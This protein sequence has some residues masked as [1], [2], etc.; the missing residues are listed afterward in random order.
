MLYNL[1]D[2]DSLSFVVNKYP[3]KQMDQSFRKTRVVVEFAEV[4]FLYG[5]GKFFPGVE[6]EGS[7][8]SGHLVEEA[9]ERPDIIR[10]VMEFNGFGRGIG[11]SSL[12]SFCAFAFLVLD[13]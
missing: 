11:Q 6:A 4:L 10:L 13:G 9:A 5:G 3:F 12:T 2:C 1:I 7:S 8:P